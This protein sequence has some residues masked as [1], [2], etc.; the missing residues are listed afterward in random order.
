MGAG[1]SLSQRVRS[2]GGGAPIV[3]LLILFGLNAV[4]ELDR[5]AFGVLL[6]EIKDHFGL[7]LTGVTTL[8]A[9]VVPAA[10][11]VGFP[12]ARLAD[13]RRRL[14]IAMI[15]AS[16]WGVFSVLTGLVP[17][18]FIL[19]LTR[20]GAGL[21]RAVNDPV[22][23]SLLS[24]YYPP[25]ARAKV[26]GFHR[27]ANTVGAF[28]GPLI[29]GFMA[30]SFGW[31]LPFII[32]AIPTFALILFAVSRLHE[33]PRTGKRIVEGD[34][35]LTHAFRI[36]WGVKSLRRIW[37]AFPFIS[38]FA[39]ALGQIM[40]LYYDEIFNVNA[41]GRGVI[42]SLDAPFIVL[43]L[44][45]GSPLIDRG[46]HSDPGRVMRMIG[47]AVLC[48][49]VFILGIAIAPALWIAVVF[50][51]AINVLGTV[52]YA[53]GFALV[54]L[55]GPPEVR[56]SAFAFFSISSLLG[57][58]ALPLVGIVGDALGLRWGLSFLIPMV[59]IGSAIL[60]SAGRFVNED[61]ARVNP[62][63]L[64]KTPEPHVIPPPSPP[65]PAE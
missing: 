18:I 49:G 29:A 45:L 21:G 3:P 55:V 65:G 51:Y 50:T 59:L 9:A 37:L 22:H 56:A 52:L 10:L 54:S 17:T 48:V 12:I 31:R 35:S 32:L 1:P 60:A 44:V 16:A 61:I 20:I 40:A 27:S 63:G 5:A 14:P 64:E 42:Q 43:G 46:M 30:T 39:L 62:F 8:S 15:G 26:F 41:A 53:G 28:F 47:L 2:L 24:D 7:S 23:G 33:P 57:V 19:G 38:F 58:V 25:S 6:P 4:D 13:R 36:L 11:L 34:V